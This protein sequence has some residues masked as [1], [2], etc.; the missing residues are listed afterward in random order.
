MTTEGCKEG[1][2]WDESGIQDFIPLDW[3]HTFFCCLPFFASLHDLLNI[4]NKFEDLHVGV[5]CRGDFCAVGKVDVGL[6]R[7][8]SIDVLVVDVLD[9]WLKMV[10]FDFVSSYSFEVLSVF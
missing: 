7:E 2:I 3:G 6:L 10:T 4:S 9:H 5:L 1:G 8:R